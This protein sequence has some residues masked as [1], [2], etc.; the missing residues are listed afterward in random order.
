MCTRTDDIKI[1]TVSLINHTECSGLDPFK[2]IRLDLWIWIGIWGS[3]CKFEHMKYFT[4]TLIKNTVCIQLTNGAAWQLQLQPT[5]RQNK[6]ETL[7]K[8][9]STT[10][11][12]TLYWQDTEITLLEQDEEGKFYR[13]LT[14]SDEWFECHPGN[15]P[16]A[17]SP[18][19]NNGLLL[20]ISPTAWTFRQECFPS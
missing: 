17:R 1:A 15:Y 12:A 2:E 7:N 9:F 10:I 16:N 18:L 14:V 5:R 4:M 8:T 19:R 6:T 3:F 20:K 13:S 11:G